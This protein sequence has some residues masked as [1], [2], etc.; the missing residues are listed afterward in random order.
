M[1]SQ[2]KS[3]V[4]FPYSKE[5]ERKY[6][7]HLVEVLYKP[8]LIIVLAVL[9]LIGIVLLS[10][11]FVPELV[12]PPEYLPWLTAQHLIFFFFTF[13]IL[14]LS[15]LLKNYFLR[16]PRS[17]NILVWSYAIG[18]CIWGSTLAAYTSYSSVYFTAYVFVTLCLAIVLVLKPWQACLLFLG[19][20]AYYLFL[21]LYAFPEQSRIEENITIAGMAA[22]LCIV[23][24]SVFYTLQ[25][26]DFYNR[27]Q[28]EE[29]LIQINSINAQL[30]ERIHIDALTG[31]R[32]RRFFDEVLPGKIRE[33][34]LYDKIVCGMM[35]DIDNF[36]DFNDRYGHQRG[37]D[38]LREVASI[39][40]SVLS[41]RD[42]FF[43]RYGGE[44]FFV[45]AVINEKENA[46]LLAERMRLAVESALIENLSAKR[47]QVTIS[48]GVSILR[49]NDNLETLTQRADEAVY[50]SKREGRNR[51]SLVE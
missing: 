15:L 42:T 24:A 47:G 34:Q 21:I 41:A 49:S 11:V 8:L 29:Q 26:R 25:T 22:I 35:F 36:K 40:N 50:V 18:I 38:C 23:V 30:Q 6:R 32:N 44:E 20:Y 14:C 33:F 5:L 2:F 27:V 17:Y 37:D 13:I 12:A 9:L 10:I 43:V 3:K 7:E 39:V 48:I 46:L 19:N 16:S 31:L 1:L 4:G 51:V 45:L 28:V